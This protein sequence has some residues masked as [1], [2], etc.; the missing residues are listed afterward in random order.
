MA[1]ALS[2]DV[3]ERVVALVFGGATTRVAASMM[4]VS[5]ASAVRW[6]QRARAT[7]VSA[8]KPGGRVPGVCGKKDRRRKFRLHLR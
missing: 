2:G 7:G 8:P 6:S 1:R 4:N 3:R 5:N